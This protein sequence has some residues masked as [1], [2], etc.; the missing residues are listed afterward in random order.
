MGI[1]ETGSTFEIEKIMIVAF[2]NSRIVASHHVIEL[3]PEPHLH[4]ERSRS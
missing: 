2:R 3:G 1:P 4:R